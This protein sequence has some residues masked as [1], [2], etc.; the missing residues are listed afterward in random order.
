VA[1]VVDGNVVVH[2]VAGDGGRAAHAGEDAGVEDGHQG[3][4]LGRRR[5]AAGEDLLGAVAGAVELLVG[6]ATLDD[7]GALEGDAGE[8][9]LGLGVGEDAGDA[10]ERGGT[11]GFGVAADG[12]GGDGDVAS[13]GQGA[14]LGE[15]LDG[16][17]VIEDEDEVGELKA[18]LATKAAAYRRDGARS[19][20]TAVG[21]AGDDEATS[22]AAGA[23]EAGLEDGED[24]EALS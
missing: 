16:R 13:E 3:L 18:D 23:E 5:D 17:D 22:E 7:A 1:V 4:S 6:V 2:G 10:L 9:A 24:R 14:G 11:C 15:G 12:A 20:P 19:G 8:E 21:E